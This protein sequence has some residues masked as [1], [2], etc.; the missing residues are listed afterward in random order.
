L[1]EYFDRVGV[2]VRVG[3]IRRLRKDRVPNE[4]YRAEEA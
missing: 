1:L 4:T 2:T 3:D